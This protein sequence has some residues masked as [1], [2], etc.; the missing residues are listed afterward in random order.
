MYKIIIK[1]LHSLLTIFL[2][3]LVIFFMFQIIPGD[4]ILEKIG[5]V[6]DP[7]LESALRKQFGMDAPPHIRYFNYLSGIF[8]GDL[9]ISIRYSVP[10]IELMKSRLPN[11]LGITALAMLI[12][13]LIGIPL[14]VIT[15]KYSKKSIGFTFNIIT[16]ICTSIPSFFMAVILTLIF[17]IWLRLF[18]V[19]LYVPIDQDF[20]GYLKGLILPSLAVSI[21]TMATVARYTRGSVLEQLNMNYVRTA[22]NKGLT[23]NYIL[24]KHI[25]PNT[26]I[27][28]L[29]I[30]GILLANILGGTIVVES[31]FSIPGIGSLLATGIKSRDFPLV[32]G[33]S[34]YITICVVIVFL[35]LDILY[36]LIDPRIE[37]GGSG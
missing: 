7:A 10:V 16:Q 28:V 3:S 5:E 32:Q 27:T 33:I 34:L 22:Q 17:S 9:G 15:A 35:I 21:G 24:I 29:T 18:D 13:I 8:S 19:V 14:G 23:E 6:S 25:L 2:V 20:F 37:T 1:I 4:A 30:A 36:N 12:T 31:A 11:T 26:L